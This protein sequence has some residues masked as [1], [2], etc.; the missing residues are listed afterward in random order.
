MKARWTSIL[1]LGLFALAG[2]VAVADDVGALDTSQYRITYRDRLDRSRR[3]V[4]AE[5]HIILPDGG[6]GTLKIKRAPGHAA[7]DP[8]DH[9]IGDAT[10]VKLYTEADIDTVSIAGELR[11]LVAKDARVATVEAIGY[12]KR[13]KMRS[14]VG[15]FGDGGIVATTIRSGADAVVHSVIDVRAPF[16]NVRL[17][18]VALSEL[19][20]PNQKAK[21]KL[22][23]RKF[24]DDDGDQD[25]ASTLITLGDENVVRV[26]EL[27]LLKVV[28]GGIYCHA[29]HGG[30]VSARRSKIETRTVRYRLRR[31]GERVDYVPAV[32]IGADHI[33]S[34][35]KA[36]TVK[37]RGGD[38]FADGSIL[39]S[40]DI[41]ALI[42]K[43]QRMPWEDE[44]IWGDP[45]PGYRGGL[46]VSPIIFAGTDGVP[47]ARGGTFGDAIGAD[48]SLLARR[49]Y[50]LIKR[51]DADSGV[52]CRMT[53]PREWTYYHGYQ[54]RSG[55][56]C[57]GQIRRIK[58]KP[59]R[60]PALPITVIDSFGPDICGTPF[61]S[62]EPRLVNGATVFWQENGCD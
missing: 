7:Y 51:I 16:L 5:N 48:P 49:D 4:V 10:L 28:G 41:D 3:I 50:P 58:T 62:N 14:K 25:V 55:D 23:A 26:G 1:A 59:V 37:T 17:L 6:Y 8:I 56:T 29:I 13:V 35:S 39:A 38:I 31:G 44:D 20:A 33:W 40:G 47:L 34:N 15:H 53:G 21:I 12:V 61:S 52:N 11:N 24:R 57:N 43:T 45:A 54:I 2:D 27:R 30:A 32:D 19:D 60:D 42:A 22:T 36:L 46:V 18:G 9:V